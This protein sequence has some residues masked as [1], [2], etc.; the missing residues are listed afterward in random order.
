[1]PWSSCLGQSM[2]GRII[3]AH[4]VLRDLLEYSIVSL[5][6]EAVSI[7]Q[8]ALLQLPQPPRKEHLH[9]NCKC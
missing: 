6:L 9:G 2:A 8:H 7:I 1:M 5:P 3:A 4:F